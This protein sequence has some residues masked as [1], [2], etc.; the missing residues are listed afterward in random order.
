MPRPFTNVRTSVTP[1]AAR[2]VSPYAATGARSGLTPKERAARDI[3]RT[4]K[5]TAA[6]GDYGFGTDMVSGANTVQSGAVQFFSPQLSTDFLELPQSLRERREIYR[7]FYNA[8]PIVGQAIDLHTELP[9]SKVRLA[10]PKPTTA[11]EGFESPEDYGKYIF[12]FFEKM[13]KR[14]KLF[15]RLITAVHHYYLDGN[16]FLFLEDSEVDVPQEVGYEKRV[17]KHSFVNEAGD[18]EEKDDVVLVEREN[19]DDEEL[20]YYQKHYQGWDRMIIL[21]I[22][23]VKI[24]SYGFT[25]KIR[26]ELIPSDRDRQLIEQAKLG[27]AVAEQM[28]LEIPVEVREHLEHGRNIPLGGD[29]DEG[30]FVYHLAG[31]R[32]AGEDLGHSILDRCHAEGTLVLAHREGTVQQLPIEDLDPDTDEVLSDKGVWRGFEHGVRHVGEDVAV[33]EVAKLEAPIVVTK[34]HKYMVLRDD[35]VVETVA[36]DIRDGDYL[37]VAQIP[38]T[39]TVQKVDLAEYV[40]G[41]EETYIGKRSGNT[42][43]L[44][45]EVFD[46]TDSSFLVRYAKEQTGPRKAKRAADVAALLQWAATLTEPVTTCS[47]EVCERF[48]LHPV[49]LKEI[50]RHLATLGYPT[51]VTRGKKLIFTPFMGEIPVSNGDTIRSHTRW[52]D[53]NDDLGYFLGYYLGDGH[54]ARHPSISYGYL[55]FTYGPNEP[56]SCLSME[57]VRATL[58]RLGATR[59]E[60]TVGDGVLLSSTQHVLT[61]WV[62]DNFGCTSEDKHL[63]AWIYDAPKDFLLGVLRGFIDSDGCV[64]H[65]KKGSITIILGNTNPLLI[66]QLFLLCTSFG[67]PASKCKASEPRLVKQADGRLSM[68]KPFYRPEFTHGPSVKM[69]FESGFLAKRQDPPVWKDG[70]SGSRHKTVDGRLYYRVQEVSTSYYEGRVFSLNVHEDHTFFAGKCSNFNCLR[71]LYYVDKLR[72]AQTQIASRAMTPKRIVWAEGLSDADT[73]ALREQVDLAL[74]DPD[75]TIVTNYELHWEDIGSRDRLLDM[76]GE[77]ERIE[78]RLLAGL[79]VTEALMSGEAIYSGDR[80]KLEVINTRYLLLREMLQEMVEDY[81]F[82]PVARRKGFVEKD[83]WGGEVVLY[84]RLSF[85][86]LPLRDS[87]DTYDALFNLYQKGSISVDVILEMFNIDPVDTKEKIEKDMFTVNDSTFNEVIR[88]IDGEVGRMMVEK[89]DVMERIAK[90]LGL[91]VKEEPKAE[92]EGRF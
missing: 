29:P 49:A 38:L 7:H 51:T 86:R 85:T 77:Y 14:I 37:R 82:K 54:I 63:P 56:C 76:S 1:M 19:K 68:A 39:E 47:A 55:C 2:A 6:G 58:D 15:Q 66:E 25:D 91:K 74:V 22:D 57:K 5:R 41:R 11:P 18:A 8:D 21:P 84:P 17:E 4:I 92:G 69:V 80:L 52:L 16:A 78:K 59:S 33:I 79:G 48:G 28:V 50:R 20:A 42:S 73:E 75:Y 89:T 44:R 60:S 10:A 71:D 9:L 34:D 64:S 87:Q 35:T 13:C 32:G 83:K 26:V 90:Y 31:R 3:Q 30:S 12:S 70:R 46:K 53:L 24:Q 27:D 88:G 61:R 72:Q 81:F 45:L 43:P 62:A 23:Q 67:I 65:N 40:D 36:G